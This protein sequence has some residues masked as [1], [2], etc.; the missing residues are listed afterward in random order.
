[1]LVVVHRLVT[2]VLL[3][4]TVQALTYIF[5]CHQGVV[6]VTSRSQ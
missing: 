4:I 6:V 2:L 3:H 5:E 1:M